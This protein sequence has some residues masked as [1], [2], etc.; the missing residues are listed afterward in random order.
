LTLLSIAIEYR[1]MC[2]G[3]CVCAWI[4]DDVDC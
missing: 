4:N 3:Q 2:T 1:W